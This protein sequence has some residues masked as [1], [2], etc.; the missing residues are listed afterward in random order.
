MVIIKMTMPRVSGFDFKRLQT[1]KPLIFGIISLGLLL[2]GFGV[3]L[4]FGGR[5]ELAT[6]VAEPHQYGEL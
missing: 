2:L 4:R 5:P 6:L 1:S 3:R